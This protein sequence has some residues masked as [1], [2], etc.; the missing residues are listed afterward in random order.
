M[1]KTIQYQGYTIQSSPQYQTDTGKWQLRI[2]ISVDGTGTVR[3]RELSADGVYATEQEADVHGITF[4]QRVIDGKVDGQS[5]TDLKTEDR[6]T[7]PRLRV[8][9]RTTFSGSP[10]LEGTG[11]MLDLSSGGCRIESPVTVEAGMSLELRIN[12]PDLEWPLM[13]EAASVQWVSGQTFGLAFFRI[14][15]TELER[16]GQL[17]RALTEGHVG[18]SPKG[19]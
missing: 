5:V 8:Q 12:V 6:R 7:T 10:T 2:F 1:E 16:L 3:T 9:F 11:L 19:K 15:E 4:G 17:I 13:I 14:R 18:F